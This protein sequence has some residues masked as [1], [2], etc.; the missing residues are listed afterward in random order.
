MVVNFRGHGISRGT[1][2]LTWT[3]MLIKKRKK[4]DTYIPVN[5]WAQ[6]YLS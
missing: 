2:K 3:I 5:E 1:R 6:I 4:N